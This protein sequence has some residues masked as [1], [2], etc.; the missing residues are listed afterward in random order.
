[1]IPRRGAVK[2]KAEVRTVNSDESEESVGADRSG[3]SVGEA[4]GLGEVVA[5]LCGMMTRRQISGG[6]VRIDEHISVLVRRSGQSIVLEVLGL[7]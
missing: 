4:V 7:L 6:S 2:H 3:G 1:M 5:T